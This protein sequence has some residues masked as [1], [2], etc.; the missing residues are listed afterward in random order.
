MKKGQK[1]RRP[2]DPYTWPKGVGF[3]RSDS[4]GIAIATVCGQSRP[5]DRRSWR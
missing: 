4:D 1:V 5:Y 3:V 2:F